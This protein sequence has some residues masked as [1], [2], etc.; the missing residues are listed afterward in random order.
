VGDRSSIFL[1]HDHWH[2]AGYLLE[3]HGY[4]VIYDSGLSKDTRLSS[5]IKNNDWFWQGAR[6][7]D[8]VAIQSRLPEITFGDSNMPIW[9][10][11]K[12]TYSCADTWD[13]LR[14][15]LP[16][17]AWWKL[18]QFFMAIPK[19]YFLS[20]L[21]FRD[22]LTTKHKLSCWGFGGNLNRLFCDGCFECRAHIF[23]SCSFS[24]KI[25]RAAMKACGFADPPCCWDD[26]VDWGIS[27][28][29]GKSM[30]VCL[31][32]LCFGLVMYHL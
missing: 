2:L 19:H 3:R 13:N 27:H 14:E 28:F 25:W 30:Q 5:I 23:F 17:V 21:V 1:C 11:S 18:V 24:H 12:G 6:S 4:C 26:V 16:K 8:L 32:Q 20:W 10:S 9:R 31:G 29:H 15:K 22:A 7:D